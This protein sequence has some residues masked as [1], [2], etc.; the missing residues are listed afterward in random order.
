MKTCGTCGL[1]LDRSCFGSSQ[2]RSEGARNA[3]QAGIRQG[4]GPVRQ[5]TGG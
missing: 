5:S 2:N 4:M 1:D 3:S